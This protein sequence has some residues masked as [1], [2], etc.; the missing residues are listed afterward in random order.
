MKPHVLKQ[1]LKNSKFL[2]VVPKEVNVT[3]LKEHTA[4]VNMIKN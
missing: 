4:K 1:D 2:I 3:D